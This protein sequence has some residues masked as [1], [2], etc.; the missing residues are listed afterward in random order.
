MSE[1][2]PTNRE[3]AQ[4]I[5]GLREIIELRFDENVKEHTQV[6]EHLKTLNGQVIKNTTFRVKWS[7]AYI[8]IGVFGTVAGLISVL[9][10]I[11]NSV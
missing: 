6:N 7:G 4:M 9:I 2:Q 8:V 5:R 1:G 3:L 11:K 10:N